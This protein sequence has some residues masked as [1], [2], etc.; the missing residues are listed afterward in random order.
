MLAIALCIDLCGASIWNALSQSVSALGTDIRKQ[1][2]K[3]AKIFVRRNLG[4]WSP[5]I[6]SLPA[7]FFFFVK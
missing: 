5:S 3:K 7:K 1:T 2:Q 4:G 6:F